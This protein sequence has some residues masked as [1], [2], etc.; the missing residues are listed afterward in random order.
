MEIKRVGCLDFLWFAFGS[1]GYFAFIS[2][3]VNSMIWLAV[4]QIETWA[5][6]DL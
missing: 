2:W 3:W 5:D 4:I 1:L 6:L